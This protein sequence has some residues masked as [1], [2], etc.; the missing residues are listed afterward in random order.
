MSKKSGKGKKSQKHE[1][2]EEDNVV[3]ESSPESISAAV[4][5]GYL[6]TAI[7]EYYESTG[8]EALEDGDEWKAGTKYA[9]KSKSHI[10][11]ELDVEIRKAFLIQIKKFQK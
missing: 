9:P 8:P 2:E 7:I 5:I 1:I 10:P 3:E 6:T 4:E 11:S